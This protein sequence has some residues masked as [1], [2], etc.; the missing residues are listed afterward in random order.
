MV[1][2]TPGSWYSDSMAHGIRK[3]ASATSMSA[4]TVT[5]I[6]RYRPR[7]RRTFAEFGGTRLPR[8]MCISLHARPTAVA[9]MRDRAYHLTEGRSYSGGQRESL[10]CTSVKEGKETTT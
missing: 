9:E 5:S 3:R 10:R 2:S 8:G 4:A 1:Q 6:S 7:D